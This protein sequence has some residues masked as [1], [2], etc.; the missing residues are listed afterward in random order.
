MYVGYA[1][2]LAKLRRDGFASMDAGQGEGT[3]TTRPLSFNG[4]HLFV[5]VECPEGALRVGLLDE[6]NRPIAPFTLEN[7]VPVETDSTL[8]HVTWKNAGDVQRLS[9]R[10]IRLR[11]TLTK[12]KL[13]SF[14]VSPDENG[15]SHGFVAAGGP[16]FAGNKDTVGRDASGCIQH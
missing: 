11:F 7:C 13:Y 10:P 4:K 1:M 12:G 16:G 8:C 15:A 14:W 3:L 2:G 5:N 9:G 6:E